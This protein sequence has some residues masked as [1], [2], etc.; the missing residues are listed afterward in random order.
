M[1]GRR[2]SSIKRGWLLFGLSS[3]DDLM[4]VAPI[5]G[6]FWWH[7]SQASAATSSLSFVAAQGRGRRR[8]AQ[9][10]KIKK[11]FKMKCSVTTPAGRTWSHHKEE[12]VSLSLLIDDAS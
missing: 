9:L 12:N 1:K 2:S 10:T 4:C 7:G 3:A 6:G 8:R 11:S 5:R